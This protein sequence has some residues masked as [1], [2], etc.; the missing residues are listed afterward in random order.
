[1]TPFTLHRS[2]A[3]IGIAVCLA[4]RVGGAQAQSDASE[5]SALSAVPI[6]V[7]V[8][9]PL[10]ILSAGVTLTV[11]TVQASAVG[12]VWVLQRASDGAHASVTLSA[13]AAGGVSVAVGTVVEVTAVST[14]WILSTAGRVTAFIPNEI[15]SAMLYNERVTQ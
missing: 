8:T 10:A 1:M 12:T 9:A 3:C 2:I 14:G 5:A 7:S 4:A 15:G 6:A 11:V 13:K